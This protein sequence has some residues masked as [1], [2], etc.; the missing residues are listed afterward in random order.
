MDVENIRPCKNMFSER[1][2]EEINIHS[3]VKGGQSMS[4]TLIK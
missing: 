4:K 1:K 2:G 3:S